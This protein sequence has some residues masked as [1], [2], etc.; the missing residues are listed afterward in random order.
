MTD[1]TTNRLADAGDG[2][3]RGS[4]G[5][6]L[7]DV[8]EILGPW[9][10]R[11]VELGFDVDT[12]L[13]LSLVVQS[14]HAKSVVRNAYGD[15]FPESGA[16]SI[17]EAGEALRQFVPHTRVFFHRPRAVELSWD[18]TTAAGVYLATGSG[19]LASGLAILRRTV[20]TFRTLTANEMDVV[21]VMRGICGT[22]DR[23][24]TTITRAQIAD[25]YEGAPAAKQLDLLLRSLMKKGVII[26]SDDGW[27]LVP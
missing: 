17:A 2:A 9:P 6:E 18:A 19:S 21:L 20:Q 25:V 12:D 16:T 24:R 15:R 5:W 8:T 11:I 26:E 7:V 1:V 13:V 3:T 10:A 23:N 14:G 22:R 4:Q 27:R